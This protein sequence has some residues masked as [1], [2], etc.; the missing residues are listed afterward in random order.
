MKQ[1]LVAVV[2]YAQE[3]RERRAVDGTN[4]LRDDLV[5]IL[6]PVCGLIEQV[7]PGF[8]ACE[9]MELRIIWRYRLR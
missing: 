3:V 1:H 5:L 8:N 4:D 7:Q 9:N 2:P 6:E